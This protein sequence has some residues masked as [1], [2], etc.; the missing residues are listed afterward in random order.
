MRK[1]FAE[2][3]KL[4]LKEQSN[5]VV[6]LGDI[7]VGLF[8]NDANLLPERCFNVG[9]LEQSMISFAAGLKHS[10]FDVIIHTI[11]PFLVER[12]FEQIKVDIAYNQ[13]NV[14]IVSA[15]APYEYNKLGPTH[16]CSNDVPLMLMFESRIKVR[17]PFS[18]KYLPLHLEKSFFDK[19]V[20]SYIR[21][22]HYQGNLD[23][24]R[25]LIPNRILA[26]SDLS[27]PAT[28]NSIT[29][30][31]GESIHF[32]DS[33]AALLTTSHYIAID[34]L[35]ITSALMEEISEF[36]KVIVFEPYSMPILAF[37]LRSFSR[38]PRV[39]SYHYPNSIEDGIFYRP[40][41]IQNGY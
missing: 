40:R 12:A 33:A 36:D 37:H 39:I 14:V 8:T 20:S 4:R 34:E 18:S 16:H 41:F 1:E 25:D 10:G 19:K 5:F 21:L 22:N 23:F 26:R 28:G 30:L 7:S 15:N 35:P 3:A 24:Q 31:V 27:G 6:L 11:S 29:V 9:I 38:H 32:D 17:M 2:W 13:N